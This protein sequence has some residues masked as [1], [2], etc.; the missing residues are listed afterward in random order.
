MRDRIDIL[1]HVAFVQYVYDSDEEN[2]IR[3]PHQ[4]T[5]KGHA[6]GYTRRK[7]SVIRKIDTNL[8]SMG[9]KEAVFQAARD[10]SGVM[11]VDSLSDL[12]HGPC[13]GYY[14]NEVKKASLPA[15]LQGKEKDDELLEVLLKMKCEEEPFIRKVSLEK[16][17]LSI[18]LASENQLEELAKYSTSELDFSIVQLDPTFFFFFVSHT[19]YN[20]LQSEN[21]NKMLK[22]TRKQQLL[23][24]TV[25]SIYNTKTATYTT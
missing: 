13:Q 12:P 8:S 17:N 6:P 4:N 10:A 18:V 24:T 5:K 20:L 14:R 1:K 2:I 22:K 7:A 25:I 16:A 21:E 9:P 3:K 19:T 11:Q 23:I 15:Y